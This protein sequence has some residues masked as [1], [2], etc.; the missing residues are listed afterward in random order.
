MD[1]RIS[2]SWKTVVSPISASSLSSLTKIQPLALQV[3]E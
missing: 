2:L 1:Y 3:I